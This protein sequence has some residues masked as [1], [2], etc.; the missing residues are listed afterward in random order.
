MA[1]RKILDEL[2][3]GGCRKQLSRSQKLYETAWSGVYWCGDAKCAFRIMRRECRDDRLKVS[4]PCN[5]EDGD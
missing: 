4:D 5:W 3:C 2:R 1:K